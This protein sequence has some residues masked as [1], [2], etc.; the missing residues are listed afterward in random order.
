MPATRC[1]IEGL[2][3]THKALSAHLVLVVG[4][5]LLSSRGAILTAQA[6]AASVPHYFGALVA[7]PPIVIG[8]ATSANTQFWTTRIG[9]LDGNGL[10]D[11]VGPWGVKLASAPGSFLPAV[12]L[13]ASLVAVPPGY[14]VSRVDGFQLA[15]VN[16]DAVPDI[17]MRVCIT[18]DP[19]AALVLYA[20]Y[21]FALG[22][23]AGGLGQ[24]ATCR[25]FSITASSGRTVRPRCPCPCR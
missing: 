7:L 6:P 18:N 5:A 17:V 20:E 16:Q 22:N 12:P 3:R 1:S 8:P 15:Q 9:D 23:G 14:H 13:A 10:E 11:L 2:Q 4:I 21:V 19:A 24:F 25:A